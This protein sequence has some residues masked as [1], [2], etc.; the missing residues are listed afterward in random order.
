MKVPVSPGPGWLPHYKGMGNTSLLTP[1]KELCP[2]L[3]LTWWHGCKA[4]GEQSRGWSG[5]SAEDRDWDGC[6]GREA[7]RTAVQA[8]GP[9]GTDRLAASRL[10]LSEQDFSD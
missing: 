3:W 6:V 7:Q 9:R 2:V 4:A 1:Y 5:G 10:A 8:E